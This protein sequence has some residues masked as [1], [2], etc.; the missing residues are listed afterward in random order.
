MFHQITLAGNLG[1][2]PEMRYTQTGDAVMNLSVATNRTY[3][4]SDGEQVKE[5]IYVRV[6]VWIKQAEACNE[7]LHKGS[8][9]LVVRR[10]N[11]DPNTGGP[12]LWTR[13]KNPIRTR[14]S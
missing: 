4:G 8:N 5:T 2:N 7:Y 14:N 12:R 11:A 13:P 3:K 6:S 1:R 9:V 10:L